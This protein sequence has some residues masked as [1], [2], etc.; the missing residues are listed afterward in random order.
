[1]K[2]RV[3]EVDGLNSSSFMTHLAYFILCCLFDPS[4]KARHVC[5]GVCEKR[6]KKN[7][8]NY[9]VSSGKES[10]REKLLPRWHIL[11]LVNRTNRDS[12]GLQGNCSLV[13]RNPVL[14]SS[15]LIC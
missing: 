13:L 7:T 15:K 3:L 1:M 4:L 2:E 11:L 6:H 8:Y 12:A 10:G 5:V 9:S 14:V